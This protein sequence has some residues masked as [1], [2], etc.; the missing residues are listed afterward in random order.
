MIG[1]GN[2][3]SVTYI[4]TAYYPAPDQWDA[5]FRRRKP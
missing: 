1:V 5:T 4:I 2:A 3:I